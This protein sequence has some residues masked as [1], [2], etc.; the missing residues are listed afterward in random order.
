MFYIKINIIKLQFFRYKI[1][2][3]RFSIKD[4]VGICI[5]NDTNSYSS[6]LLTQLATR[7]RFAKT[8]IDWVQH[9]ISWEDRTVAMETK[10]YK[11]SVYAMK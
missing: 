10:N 2:L 6:K 3:K 9:L 8:R 7:W 1:D 5:I 11:R 4:R